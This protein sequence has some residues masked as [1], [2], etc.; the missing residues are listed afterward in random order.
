MSGGPEIRANFRVCCQDFDEFPGLVSKTSKR[1]DDEGEELSPLSFHSCQI[2]QILSVFCDFGGPKDPVGSLLS[3]RVGQGMNHLDIH[4]DDTS[5]QC[6]PNIS[7]SG[8]RSGDLEF[9]LY[10]ASG[11]RLVGLPNDGI[12]YA[13]MSLDGL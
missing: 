11:T 2:F 3:I 5:A 7:A 6:D 13:I 12:N 4:I 1:L 10:P 8:V 9:R